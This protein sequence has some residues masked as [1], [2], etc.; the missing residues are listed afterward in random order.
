MPVKNPALTTRRP[1]NTF[2]KPLAL[3]YKALFKA[4]GKG[5]GHTATGKWAELASDTAEAIASIGIATDPEELA[6]LLIKRSLVA[7]LFSLL[8]DHVGSLFSGLEEDAIKKIEELDLKTESVYINKT[9]FD[10]P[11]K[12]KVLE[13][14]GQKLYSWLEAVGIESTAAAN[15]R[16]RLPAYFIFAINQE[17]RKNRKNYAPILDSISTPF[18]AASEKEWAWAEYGALLS[19]RVQESIF[20][21]PF[22]LSQI[23]VPLN[24]YYVRKKDG[25]SLQIAKE[26]RVVIPLAKELTDWL[27]KNNP[28]DA[29][30]VIS[31]GPGSGKSSFARIFANSVGTQGAIK[32]IF[33]P[34]HLIDPTKDLIHEIGRFFKDEGILQHNPLD[35]EQQTTPILA[36]FDG[37]DELSSL[38]KAAAETASAFVREVERVTNRFNLQEMRLRVLLSG[39][40]VS[41]QE[42]QSDFR[43][44][45]QV[46]TILPYHLLG[47]KFRGTLI[48]DGEEYEDPEKLL[49]TDLRDVWWSNY[50]SLTGRPYTGLPKPLQRDDLAEVTGQ[51]LLNYLVALSYTRNKIDFT[52]NV[53]LNSV[54]GDLVGA[55][56]ER[57]Y[58]KHKSYGPIRH[59]SSEEFARVLEEVG[60]AAWHGDGRSTTIKEIEDHCISSGLGTLL[61]YFKEGAEAG[62]TKLLA[63]FFFR[64]HGERK[65]GYPTFVFTHKSFGE[66]LTAKRIVRAILRM[67]KELDNRSESP[68]MG[69]DEKEALRHWVTVCGP[70]AISPYLHTFLLNEITLLPLEEATRRQKTLEKLFNYLLKNGLP[71][72]QLNPGSFKQALFQSRNSEEALLVIVNGLARSTRILAKISQDDATIF[73]T[74]FRR[75][76]GQRSGPEGTLVNK[77]MSYLDLNGAVLDICDLYAANL[78][79]SNLSGAHLHFSILIQANFRG[80]K[81]TGALLYGTQCRRADF[82]NADL[83]ECDLTKSELSLA[84]FTDAVLNGARVGHDELEVKPAFSRAQKSSMR[85]G[86]PTARAKLASKEDSDASPP[87]RKSV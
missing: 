54:Y 24:A 18:T 66:Y 30:R 53:N 40:E 32:T 62:V 75:I 4:V 25:D 79:E 42:N 60:L 58:E 11:G 55:V 65:S 22:S 83:S 39:R 50:G 29:I 3:D 80:A 36:I 27:R 5:A 59:M 2:T 84:D 10:N 31:G 16:S 6:F 71:M 8:D 17:W 49:E 38:G 47:R 76:Q 85:L 86:R 20:D 44:D 78:Q 82:T 67:C 63:A 9:F 46:L 51:P 72:E 48:F 19:K 35:P 28:A 87:R 56:H 7:S 41:I 34:L 21:E 15:I 57:G 13:N 77:C 64:Q 73:G 33:V 52:R 23:Y 69:W 74:W 26:C 45:R 70:T 12:I 81:L 37:L 14:L 68:D 61:N 1:A 43:R